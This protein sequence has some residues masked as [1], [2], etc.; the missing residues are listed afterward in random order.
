[1]STEINYRID[2]GTMSATAPAPRID[3]DA[4]LFASEDGV[5]ASLS[6]APVSG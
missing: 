3:P 6:T 5:V 1:M 4:P 2:Y